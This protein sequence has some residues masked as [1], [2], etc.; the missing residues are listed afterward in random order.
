MDGVIKKFQTQ[1]T[2]DINKGREVSKDLQ[3]EPYYMLQVQFDRV[4]FEK[5]KIKVLVIKCKN[6]ININIQI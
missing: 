5:S 3:T 1:I 6:I 2:E 4:S